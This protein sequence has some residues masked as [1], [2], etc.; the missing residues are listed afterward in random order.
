MQARFWHSLPNKKIQCDLC[1]RACKIGEGKRGFCHGRVNENG[2]LVAETYGHPVSLSVDPIEKK[3][4]YHFLPGSH[5]L[6]FGTV[7]CNLGCVFCQNWSLSRGESLTDNR[8]P[9][10]GSKRSTVN[11]QRSTHPKDIAQKAKEL[12]CPSVAFTYNEPIIF[13][14]YAIDV[15]K[16]CHK[17]GL[18]TVAVTN[19]YIN[20]EPGKEF[21]KYMD[22]ANVDLKAFTDRF[23]KELCGAQLQP[24]LD[25]LLLIKKE[26]KTWLEITTLLIPG[27]NDSAEE[28]DALTKWIVKNLGADVPLHFSAYHPDYKY[29]KA[30]ATSLNVLHGA[31][32]KALENGLHHVYTG[33]VRETAGSTTIC[34]TCHKPIIERDGY[35]IR[36]KFMKDNRCIFCGSACAGVF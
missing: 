32:K 2:T 25:T 26:T 10:A 1:P 28:I 34:V 17:L 19:G 8:L 24:V 14:E 33:N 12:H 21:F 15:A 11:G 29:T 5:V 22:A 3:P 30:P 23:Y 7:G 35:F 9:I 31:R 18:K 36:K 20:P 13:F 6:S 16:E 27:E 4:L